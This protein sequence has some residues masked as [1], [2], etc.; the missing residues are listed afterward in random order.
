MEPTDIK[1]S[2]IPNKANNK[3]N[4]NGTQAQHIPCLLAFLPM[5]YIAWSDDILTPSEVNSIKAQINKEE[6]IC[7][8][9]KQMIESFLN[10]AQPPT[11]QQMQEWSNIIREQAQLLPKEE[12]MNLADLG[13]NIARL[14]MNFGGKNAGGSSA[15]T[16]Q[17]TNN[18]SRAALAQIEE[19]LGVISQEAV[20]DIL[21][22][23]RPKSI[24]ED[25]NVK[26]A[27]HA[28]DVQK[29]AAVLDGKQAKM[30]NKLRKLFSDPA[31]KLRPMPT[32]EEYRD[33]VYTWC[34]LLAEQGLGNIAYPEIAGGK[35]NMEG[36]MT[37]FEMM[38]YHDL[39]LSIKFGVQFGLFGGSIAGLGTEK[40]FV[41]YL[42]PAGTLELPGCFAMTEAGHGSNV[43]DIETTAIYDP[44]TEQFIINTPLESA[45]KIYIGN[46]AVHGQ[47]ATVF[48]Q[49]ETNGESYGVHAFLVPIRDKNGNAIEGVRIE[50]NGEKLG[51][52]GVDNGMIWFDNVK[53]PR[54][55]LL[56]RFGQV[57][58]DGT[59]TSDIPSENRRF[60]TMLGTL[61]GGRV[62][63]PIAGM[64]AA[65]TSLTIALRYASKRRQFGPAEQAETIILDYPS[66]QK[67]LMPLLANLYAYDFA[68]KYMSER[69]LNKTEEDVREIEALAAGLKAL[70]SWNTTKTI[71]ECRE[72]CGGRGYLSENR[73]ADLK[74][75]TEIFTTFEGDNTVLMQLVAKG[76]LSEFKKEMG[77]MDFMGILKYI[78]HQTSQRLTEKNPIIV[79]N[80]A[81]DHLLDA[82]FH[83]S[84]FKYREEQLLL[85]V[86]Q[87]IKKRIGKGIDSYTAFIETQNH[88]ID[89]AA[90]YIDRV[91]LEQFV[92]Q[93]EKV[94]DADVKNAL[95]SLEQL[96]ALNKI[97]EHKGYY[98]EEG[99]MESSK[100]KAI[101]KL[102][103]ELCGELAQNA[104]PLTDAFQI[105]E[106]C[107]AAPIAFDQA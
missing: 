81:K 73:F 31:F 42:K 88:L 21:K 96:Y 3:T 53:I 100:T 27:T 19:S 87:R 44:K 69:Y 78:G 76:R 82:D 48:A 35:D 25:V 2:T 8:S 9:D 107:I 41:K 67:R 90:A 33:Q 16:S 66:H 46:A 77:R 38:A 6:W 99:Y 75:D 20:K 56:D 106:Q 1:T 64:S 70:S 30:K 51:L 23:P 45:H 49:L 12:K 86:A 29:M 55:D 4:G 63:V 52:N 62:C 102:V 50:D 36:Y 15:D 89:M 58:K 95:Q 5:L 32:K 91:V 54:E 85:S 84:A 40:H 39:S 22:E 98:L 47:M 93:I 83:L 74:A 13:Y 14:S 65:K 10:P 79:R 105:P 80:T 26:P 103:N 72:A 92:L 57:A 37:A 59:Y 61:V 11:V 28:F 34:K 24:V 18:I 17:D 94:E 101:S 104:I 7:E 60:F 68:H 71:Q 43:R 97:A